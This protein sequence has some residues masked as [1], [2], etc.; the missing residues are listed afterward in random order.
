MKIYVVLNDSGDSY[1]ESLSIIGIFATKEH[2]EMLSAKWPDSYVE[3]HNL[4][5]EVR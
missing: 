3:D 2:A 5:F 1:H 4:E